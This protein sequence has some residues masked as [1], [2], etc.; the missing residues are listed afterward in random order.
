MVSVFAP[1][2]SLLGQH[3]PGVD[4][5]VVVHRLRRRHVDQRRDRIDVV[6]CVHRYATL[7]LRQR[8]LVLPRCSS[9]FIRPTERQR[10]PS[11]PSRPALASAAPPARPAPT[12][13]AS[14]AHRRAHVWASP[15]SQSPAEARGSRRSAARH[16]RRCP[17][18]LP[19]ECTAGKFA[20]SGSTCAGTSCRALTAPFRASCS[21]SWESDRIGNCADIVVYVVRSL[22]CAQRAVLASTV[23]R[24][25]PRARRARPDQRAS[26]APR[27]APATAATPPPDPARP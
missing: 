2:H 1:S 4:G 6:I 20:A 22:A 8:T 12:P 25:Q 5:S 15:Q 23:R 3:V 10:A 24:V 17:P 16:V 18:C 14:L 7:T 19:T 21:V 26:A 13:K 11:T 9:R 27:R